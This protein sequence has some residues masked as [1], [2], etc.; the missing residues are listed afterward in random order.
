MTRPEPATAPR[1]FWRETAVAAQEGGWVVMLDAHV[2]KTPAGGPLLAP[3]E[4]L[5]RLLRDEWDAQG[6]HVRAETM[7]ITRLMNVALA[8]MPTARAETL[9][10][11]ARYAGT[12]VVC[13]RAAAPAELAAR[14]AGAWDPPLAWA[15]TAL[16][17]EMVVTDGLIAV[18]QPDGA[19]AILAAF[20]DGLDDFRLTAFAH[21]MTLCGSA[22][23]AAWALSGAAS[24]AK[25]LDASRVDEIWQRERWGEDEEAAA[26][27]ASKG[28]EA[29]AVD[30]LLAA[31]G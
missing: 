25:A 12:D 28:A 10:E 11:I 8:A 13:Y 27:A 30:Q 3:T 26:V 18:V 17:V 20:A 15:R 16:G 21:V 29:E 19:G 7:P 24:C 9:A 14:Q 5:A 4:A 1:R 23:L 2:A 22:V 6:P 31:L